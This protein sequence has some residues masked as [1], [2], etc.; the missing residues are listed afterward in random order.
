VGDIVRLRRT[1]DAESLPGT[2]GIAHSRSKSGGGR[3]WAHPFV[4]CD[5]KLAYVA[6]GDYGIFADPEGRNRLAQRLA[7]AGHVFSSRQQE[8]VG[9]YPLLADGSCAHVS[10]VM[11]HLVAEF[12]TQ[13]ATPERAMARAYT[14]F[15]SEIVGLAVHADYPDC[16]V[17]ARI[18]QP[19]M[20]AH[21]PGA[22]L[23]ASAALAFPQERVE[24]L[25]PMP[26]NTTAVVSRDRVELRPFDKAPGHVAE[27][28]PWREAEER[29]VAA[30][31]RDSMQS[32]AGAHKALSAL[33][34]EGKAGQTAMT[35][36]EVLRSLTLQRRVQMADIRVPGAEPG[37]TAPQRHARILP[38]T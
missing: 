26:I 21:H 7:D 24:W 37:L 9:Q 2:V 14:E 15:P 25:A 22:C 29:I 32:V 1:T 20:L 5:G 16:V 30:L 6:N 12:L 36:Y 18:N 13:G 10:D 27:P 35:L 34:P 8:P 17:A 31:E 28:I 33:W 11:C 4:A 23:M 38:L 19:L 3:E